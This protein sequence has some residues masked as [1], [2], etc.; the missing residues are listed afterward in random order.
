MDSKFY[1]GVIAGTLTAIS[2]IPQIIKV[3]KEKKAQNVSPVMFMVLLTGNGTWFYYG[4]LIDD[5]P[6]MITNAFS[7]L[8]DL[9]MIFLN[10]KFKVKHR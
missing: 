4:L 9:V 5:L 10:Y 2:A 8:L 3:I 6:I 7:F 1:I